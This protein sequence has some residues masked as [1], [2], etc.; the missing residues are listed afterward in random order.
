[1]FIA[2]ITEI[3]GRFPP[4]GDDIVVNTPAIPTARRPHA[5]LFEFSIPTSEEIPHVDP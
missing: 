5:P 4:W 1:M 3:I 2:Y